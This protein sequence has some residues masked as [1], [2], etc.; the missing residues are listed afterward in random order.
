[1]EYVQHV[2]TMHVA[3]AS[4]PTTNSSTLHDFQLQLNLQHFFLIVGFLENSGNSSYYASETDPCLIPESKSR[5]Q[6]NAVL[7]C[8]GRPPL[9]ILS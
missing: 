9:T 2:T 1:M 4:E 6:I 8:F 3:T 5:K 7:V